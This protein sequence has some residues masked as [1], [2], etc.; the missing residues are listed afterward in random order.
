M[1]I[2]D[3]PPASTWPDL[4]KRPG[5][6]GEHLDSLIRNVVQ[7][8][9]RAG[10]GGVKELTRQFDSVLVSD[11]RVSTNEFEVAERNLPDD[12][13]QAIQVAARN[14]T[15]FHTAQLRSELSL[16]TMPGVRCWRIPMGIEAVGLY[17]PGGSAPLF[18]TV[19]MLGIPARLAGCRQVAICTP[20]QPDGSAHPAILYAARVA[21]VQQVFK[22]GGAQAIAAM[23]FGTE[24]IPRVDKILG[25]GNQYVTRAKQFVNQLGVAIDF[26]A[27]PSELMIVADET[28][29]PAFVAAD[30]IAQ[31]E[32]DEDS[33][34]VLVVNNRSIAEQ[35]QKELD[36]QLPSLPRK[37]IAMRSLQQSK[38]VILEDITAIGAF[39]NSYA[40]EHLC[41]NTRNAHSLLGLV[42][43][44][45]SV[46]IGNYSACAIGDYASGT[47]HTLPTN[48]HAKAFSGISVESFTRYVTVQEV[49]AE[50]IVGVG[51]VVERMAQEEMLEG[52]RRSVQKRVNQVQQ[53]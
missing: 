35:V 22:V 34:V 40:P 30:L 24:T 49:T 16:E 26:P 36:V 33:Q 17:V 1:K 25:P 10:D 37:H 43:N 15:T 53:R 48:G 19:L 46:F 45:G 18:S 8:V 6:E 7:R 31:A 12:L 38:V 50:G 44:V 27:G 23:A 32:H 5:A 29:T 52:H 47:N 39:V 41:I 9:R 28:A 20:P 4:C 3:Y 13:K 2:L 11:L 14:I 21:G 51:P 42:R